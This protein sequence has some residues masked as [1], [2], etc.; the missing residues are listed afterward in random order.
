MYGV[1][2]FIYFSLL[3]ETDGTTFSIEHLFCL[4]SEDELS[5]HLIYTNL[6]DHVIN[7]RP[8]FSLC[9]VVT[10]ENCNM[11]IICWF[12][13]NLFYVEEPTD[14]FFSR[15]LE[16]FH[17]SFLFLFHVW[18][19]GEL[20]RRC[21]PWSSPPDHK[22]GGL[23]ENITLAGMS[24]SFVLFCFVISSLKPGRT[25]DHVHCEIFQGSPLWND[26]CSLVK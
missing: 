9:E 3:Y 1:G 16:M 7:L 8:S 20:W 24:S 21:L 2:V 19:P 12:S 10:R 26:E 5:N 23:P 18:C 14:F 22:E 17:P 4:V 15:Y 11:F 13:I 6:R 25:S